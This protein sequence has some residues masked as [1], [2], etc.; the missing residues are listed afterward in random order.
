MSLLLIRKRLELNK[1]MQSFN[2]KNRLPNF[3]ISPQYSHRNILK[4]WN[5]RGYEKN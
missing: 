5:I 1:N 3:L 2:Y 4:K